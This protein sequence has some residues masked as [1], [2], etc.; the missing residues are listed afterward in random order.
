MEICQGVALHVLPSKKFKEIGWYIR[1]LQPLNEERASV[2]SL[3]ALMMSDRL[4]AYPSKQM[5]SRHLDDLYGMVIGAQTIGYGRSQVL[6]LRMK[7]MHPCFAHDSEE[8]LTEGIAFLREMITRPLL[9]EEC[10]QEAKRILHAKL[11]RCLLYTS[12]DMPRPPSA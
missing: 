8:Y 12:C 4:K 9:N 7:M 10:L 6:E 3:L 1:F 2:W 5:M 11:K